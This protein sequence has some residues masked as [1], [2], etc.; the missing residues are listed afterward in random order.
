MYLKAQILHLNFA[1]GCSLMKMEALLSCVITSRD[2]IVTYPILQHLHDNAV[3][4]EVITI[5]SKFMSISVPACKICMIDSLNF[6]LMPLAEMLDAFGETELAKEYF[7]HLF[8]RQEHQHSVLDHL[9]NIKFYNS[10]ICKRFPQWFEKNKHSSFNFQEETLKYCESDVDILRKCVLKFRQLF[11]NLTKTD[12]SVG[13]DC[14]DKCITIVS[15]CNLVFRTILLDHKSIG[16]N[17]PHGYRAG[18]KQSV[19]A[20]Q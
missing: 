14:F 5:G 17:S 18:A 13:I 20:Y 2:M 3:L 4:P 15:A 6:I 10:D 9:P 8:N 7:P 11:M 16:I 12:S 19:M 1:D